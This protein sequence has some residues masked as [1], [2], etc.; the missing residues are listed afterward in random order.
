M[1]TFK[2][3]IAYAAII[4]TLTSC[5]V[6]TGIRKPIAIIDAPADLE[7]KNA[8]TGEIIPITM[9]ITAATSQGNS[10]TNYKTPAI[11][12]KLKNGMI[13]ELKSNGVVKTFQIDK[14]NSIG[15]LIVEGLFTLGS[16]ALIDIVTGAN[17]MP[18]PPYIDVSSLFANKPQRTNNQIRTYIVE[19]SH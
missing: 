5:G 4:V 10:I 12:T 1:K 9:A 7:I 8:A 2:K 17:K 11:K 3:I 19:N 18:K 15:L 13:L 6:L 14:K 16:F